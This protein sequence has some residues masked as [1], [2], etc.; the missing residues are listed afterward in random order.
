MSG[1]ISHAKIATNFQIN[2]SLVYAG[3]KRGFDVVVGVIALLLLMPIFP[4]LAL[5]I[6]LDTRGPVFFKQ[7]RVGRDGKLFKFYKFR[8]MLHGADKKKEEL[9]DQNEQ[10]GPVF[11]IRSDPRITSVGRFLRRARKALSSR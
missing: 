11:K 5:M 3:A 4:L 10:D 9:G 8:S 1:A 2:D 7:D 6:K